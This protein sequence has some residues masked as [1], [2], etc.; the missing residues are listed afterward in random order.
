MLYCCYFNSIIQLQVEGATLKLVFTPGHTIDHAV[1]LLKEDNT[2][3]S[4]DCVLGEGSSVFECLHTYMKSLKILI[5][6]NPNAIYPGKQLLL[7][8]EF[9]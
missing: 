4:G 2:L 5:D 6:L 8:L 3:F 1:F 7:F 9:N